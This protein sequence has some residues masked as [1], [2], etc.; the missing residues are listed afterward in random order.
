MRLKIEVNQL[1]LNSLLITEKLISITY[2]QTVDFHILVTS[3]N[4]VETFFFAALAGCW[5]KG[6]KLVKM[7]VSNILLW[8]NEGTTIILHRLECDE[9]HFLEN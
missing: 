8:M 3:P 5:P 6:G 9:R 2:V 4:N 1:L 7:I